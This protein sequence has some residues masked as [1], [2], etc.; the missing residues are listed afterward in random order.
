LHNPGDR[1]DHRHLDFTS[2]M[3]QEEYAMDRRR[4]VTLM[5]LAGAASIATTRISAQP[6]LTDDSRKE[7]EQLLA[8]IPSQ[9]RKLSQFSAFGIEPQN[10]FDRVIFWH[11]SALEI[12]AKDHTPLPPLPQ[13]GDPAQQ[14][15]P[16]R[17]GEQ[18]GPHR[19]SYAMAVTHIA[20]FEAINAFSRAAPTPTKKYKSYTGY[21]DSGSVAIGASVDSAVAQAAHD[22]L[23]HLYP[24]KQ[25][26]I[27]S[28][29]ASDLGRIGANDSDKQNG[30]QV[31]QN[32]A[33]S[34]IDK[35]Q[36]D[37]TEFQEIK[38]SDLPPDNGIGKWAIDPIS[39]IQTALGARWGKVT[40]FLLQSGTQFRLSA[41]PAPTSQRFVKAFNEVKDI[42]RAGNFPKDTSRRE[43]E[44]FKAIFWAYDGTPNLCAPPRLY[45]EVIRTIGVDVKKISDPN[46][47][48]R[49][50]A[51]CNTAMAD[52]AI[53]AWDSK[54][55]WRYW[56]P[57]TGIR[58]AGPGLDPSNVPDPNWQPLGSPDT[59]TAGP[60]FTPP[61][62]AYPSGHATF[63]GALFQV[64]RR[65][66]STDGDQIPFVLISDEFNGQN[67][68]VGDKLPRPYL[69]SSY[70]VLSDAEFENAFSRIWLGVHWRPDGEDGILLGNKVGDWA[71][72]HAFAPV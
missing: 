3:F 62:P 15:D 49:L 59:N 70:V 9:Q 61:F 51:L 30:I 12:T 7:F 5:P 42:G 37:G 45:N 28:I 1:Y 19:S 13:G 64:M 44:K 58:W 27:D 25:G 11:K 34:I 10:L 6:A 68:G 43:G 55:Y 71:F 52:A 38:F 60:N 50:F 24:Y 66:F 39:K 48:A 65:V 2:F 18:L 47:L 31:G 53:A 54:Y 69:P 16:R 23:V 35:R 14:P 36:N 29:L 57:V 56:R 21:S 22:A 33:K 26:D 8:P 41:P 4:F 63:G 46:E 17:F 32:A 40:P 72:E 67:R 20:M